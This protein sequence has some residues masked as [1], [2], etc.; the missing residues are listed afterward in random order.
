MYS[1][2]GYHLFSQNPVQGEQLRKQ[3]LDWLDQHV[4]PGGRV[5]LAD[6]GFI[7]YHSQLNFVDSY[8]LNNAEIAQLPEASR[9]ETACLN[10]LLSRPDVIIL[11][12]AIDHGIKEYTPADVCLAKSLQHDP[13]YMLQKTMRIGSADTGYAYTIYARHIE[14]SFP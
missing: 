8:C 5:V 6:S 9:Y 14:P 7:P 12:Y 11:T 1:L 13:H 3:V 2:S 10:L 4:S